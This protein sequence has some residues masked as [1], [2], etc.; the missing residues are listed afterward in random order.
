L[1]RLSRLHATI[2]LMKKRNVVL[3][4]AAAG[5][6]A[7][8]A[9]QQAAGPQVEAARVSRRDV[10]Q[11]VVASGRIVTPHRVEVAAQVTASAAE[12]LVE[13]GDTVKAGQRLVVLESSESRAAE[14][15][16]KATYDPARAVLERNRK[17][18]EKGFVGEAALEDAQRA[19]EVA[20]TQ[21]EAARARLGYML[22]RAPASG[23]LITREVD[24]GDVVQPGKVLMVL[25]P[26]R[27]TEIVLQVD[28]RNLGRVRLGQ[29]AL[30]SAD[31]YPE[32]R[33]AAQL[34]FISPGVDAQRGTV[35]VKLRVP[36]PPEYL[37]E[38]MTVSVD[39]EI[40][41]RAGVL[42]LPADA[43]HDATTPAPW[44]LAVESG[45][46]V[47]RPVKLGLRGER[48]VEVLDGLAEGELVVPVENARIGAGRAVR[49]R[50]RE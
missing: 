36:Q 39:I 23:I 9:Y 47:R 45:R 1:G 43:V 30:A 15:Q 28:E 11:S 37:K 5:V 17:L 19:S 24:P 32:R 16:A 8:V 22:V 41:R 12:V 35:E 6:L 33:F 18:S 46:A 44:V 26:A 25:A 2:A 20:R 14:A 31:A 34:S 49:A 10:V 42:T 13:K 7:Y 4:A 50:A 27:G 38:D 48:V 40:E 21:L 29:R 3:A